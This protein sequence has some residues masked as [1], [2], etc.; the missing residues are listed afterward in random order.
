[1]WKL[2]LLLALFIG[3]CSGSIN[4]N[5]R[6]IENHDLNMKIASRWIQKN[7]DIDGYSDFNLVRATI[8]S[9]I[10]MPEDNAYYFS[11]VDCYRDFIGFYWRDEPSNFDLAIYSFFYTS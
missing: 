4:S 10:L 6:K 11:D 7:S 5:Q 3:G 9:P 1:M 2:L 8:H